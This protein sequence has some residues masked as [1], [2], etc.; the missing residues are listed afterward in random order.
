MLAG[1]EV[2]A[3]VE[4][5]AGFTGAAS[6]VAACM[7]DVSMAAAT[8]AASGPYIRSQVAA[9]DVLAIPLL[10]VPVVR[11]TR[12]RDEDI[13][14]DT[15][16][17][18]RRWEPQRLVPRPMALMALTTTATMRMA[19]G[20]VPISINIDRLRAH[21]DGGGA[22]PYRRPFLRYKPLARRAGHA[23]N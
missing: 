1:A 13:I 12:S 15:D 7:P 3:S 20:S 21:A 18:R 16:T 5:A 2:A 19:I 10:V 22:R 4:A 17:V 9:R 14:A 11:G 6:A 23:A 8:E